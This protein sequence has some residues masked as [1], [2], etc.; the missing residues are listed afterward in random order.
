M[1]GS[2]SREKYRQHDMIEDINNGNVK[3][4]DGRKLTMLSLTIWIIAADRA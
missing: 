1:V 4:R 2:D 3:S